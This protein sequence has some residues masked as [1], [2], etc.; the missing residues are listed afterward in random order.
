MT[1][2]ASADEAAD[3]ELVPRD[4]GDVEVLQINRLPRIGDDG[5][6]VAGKKILPLPHAEHERRTAPR[7]DNRIRHIAMHEDDAVGA[8]DHLQRPPQ[9][10]DKPPRTRVAPERVVVL[11]HEMREH[12][13]IRLRLEGVPFL[14]ELILQHV[15]VF[16]HAIVAEEERAAL[17]AVRMRILIGDAAVRCPARVRDAH[18]PGGRRLLDEFRKIGD[19]PDAFAHFDLPAVEHR[20]ARRIVPAIFQAPEPVEEDGDRSF[21]TDVADDAAHRRSQ[22]SEVGKQWARS[23]AEMRRADK[24]RV[25]VQLTIRTF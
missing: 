12:L 21:R 20:D 18:G 8:H 19:A 4:R 14:H 24:G 10:L 17:V 25:R 7:T 13:R 23:V 16:D 22:E 15:V 5:A 1:S 9:R 6:H 11:A 3:L 2:P